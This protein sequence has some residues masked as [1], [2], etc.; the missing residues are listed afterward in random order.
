MINPVAFTIN[1]GNGAFV[2]DIYWYGVIIAAGMVLALFVAIRN[3]KILGKNPEMFIDFSIIAI[4][5]AVIGARAHYV[6]WS[7]EFFK[8]EPFWKVF[9]IWEGG[10][11]IYGG[12]IGGFIAALLFAKIKKVS[13]LGILDIAAPSL[14]LGQAIGRWGNFANQEAYG[15]AVY[16]EKL[17]HFPITVFIQE[18]G[19]YHLATFF[20]ESMWNFIGF[21]I[22]MV[23]LRKGRREGRTFFL[24]MILY[25]LGRVVIEGMRTDSQ[26]F[27]NTDI[28]VNQVLS[29]VFIIVGAILYL[30]NRNTQDYKLSSGDE[31]GSTPKKSNP[32]KIRVRKMENQ[33]SGSGEGANGEYKA[34]TEEMRKQ[35]E[36]ALKDKE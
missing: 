3:A 24:Y 7:W 20:Y 19:Q 36:K 14:L 11:A 33:K 16:N 35:R 22:L 5:F 18:T 26:M 27:L 4:I 2:K 9:A 6:V 12:I 31:Q 28:R 32:G 1:V 8:G 10:L 23:S 29:A 25:G 30:F 13:L 17:W 21:F 34:M 15:Y